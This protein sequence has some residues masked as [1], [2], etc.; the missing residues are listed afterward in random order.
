V[1]PIFNASGCGKSACHAGNQPA[2]NLDLS[3]SSK[4]YAALVN[5]PA[6]Q[7]S[8]RTRVMPGQPN[9]SYLVNKLTGTD[10]CSG[11]RMP[12]AGSA[13]SASELDTVRVWIGGG[14]KP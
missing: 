5:V 1:F 9:S 8:V 14:A 10:M 4:G 12:K 11:S 6:S 3:S 7:C 13:L 2:E